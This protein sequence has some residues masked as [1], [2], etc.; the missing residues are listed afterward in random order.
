[1]IEYK[2]GDIL[3][4]EA[5]A[6]VNTVNCVGVMGRG[7]ALQFKNAFPANYKAYEA[8]CKKKAVVPG[9]MFVYATGKLTPPRFIINF[10]TKRHWRGKS[11][12]KDIENGLDDLVRVIQ[13]RGI[14][15]IA[16]PPLGCGLGGLDWPTVRTAIEQR[17]SGLCDVRII[18]F[19]PNGPPQ[20][21]TMHHAPKAPSMTPGRAALVA[22][23]DR[24]LRGLLDPFITLLEVHKLMYFMLAAGEP[25][26][27]RYKKATVGPYAENLRHVLHAIEGFYVTGYADGGDAPE[28]HLNIVPGAEKDAA[29]MLGQHP[30]TQVRLERVFRLVE[31]FE[32]SFGLELLASVHWVAT[33]EA[34][35]SLEALTQRIYAWNP[36]KRKFSERQIALAANV[37][38]TQGWLETWP[39]PPAQ[40][41]QG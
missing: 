32:S 10:P 38:Q 11:S 24:Y 6:I 7:I 8:A 29:A 23:M 31:G 16:I 4:E 39:T 25:L 27:L 9:S 34:P 17:L 26:N 1:M 2:S 37:L 28:K 13:E 22:L 21:G 19:E 33:R 40:R 30:E 5:D 18:L 14:T 15:S 3:R 36:R 20:S 12:L 35:E 41:N